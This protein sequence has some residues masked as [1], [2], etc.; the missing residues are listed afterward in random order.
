MSIGESQAGAACLGGQ[1]AVVE[2]GVVSDEGAAVGEVG[3]PWC[4]VAEMWLAV[5]HF[6]CDAVDVCGAGF[7]S[8][9]KHG[10][11]RVGDGAG[12]C[13]GQG[14]DADY[15]AGVGVGS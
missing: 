5:E 4:D 14:G 12:V 3:D 15:S 9:V 8:R 7:D 11:D 6:A 2:S 1:K 10:H 13:D